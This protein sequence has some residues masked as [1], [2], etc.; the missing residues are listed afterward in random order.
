MNK[1]LKKAPSKEE[2]SAFVERRTY[3]AR[4]IAEIIV[5]RMDEKFKDS[6]LLLQSSSLTR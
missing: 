4:R 2:M 6:T 3:D 1:A 5:M